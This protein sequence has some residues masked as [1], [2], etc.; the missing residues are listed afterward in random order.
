MIKNNNLLGYAQILQIV[1]DR[2]VEGMYPVGGRIPSVREMAVEMEVNPI[3]V[4][5]SYEK[6]CQQGAIYVQRGMG[7]YVADE[8]VEILRKERISKFWNDYIPELERIMNLLGISTEELMNHL[9]KN[10]PKE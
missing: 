6:L 4:T 5:R 10:Q 3:T 1:G 7:Y 9:Q 8:A 2:I